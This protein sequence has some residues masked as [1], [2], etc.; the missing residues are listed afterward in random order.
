MHVAAVAAVV[1]LCGSS[2]FVQDFMFAADDMGMT[3]PGEY[4]Y[5]WTVN[6]AVEIERPKHG[7]SSRPNKDRAFRPLYQVNSSL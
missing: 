3:D 5:L 7:H 4:A 6:N 2:E 1:I